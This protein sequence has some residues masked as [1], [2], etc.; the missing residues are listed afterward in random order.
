VEETTPARQEL[1][2]ILADP[3]SSQEQIIQAK[4]VLARRILNGPNAVRQVCE[5][6]RLTPEQSGRLMTGHESRMGELEAT[7][8]AQTQR[9][10]SLLAE[11]QGDK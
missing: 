6:H 7:T 11:L 9:L 1:H 4:I 3:A 5:R 10:E 8:A 2:A